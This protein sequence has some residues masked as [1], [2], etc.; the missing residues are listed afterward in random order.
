MYPCAMASEGTSGKW[1]LGTHPKRLGGIAEL[2]ATEASVSARAGDLRQAG[3]KVEIFLSQLGSPGSLSA[4]RLTAEPPAEADRS[5]SAAKE[6]VRPFQVVEPTAVA[7]GLGVAG[8]TL[9]KRGAMSGLFWFIAGFASC[10]AVS[11]FGVALVVWGLP[12]AR[13]Q[14][15]DESLPNSREPSH[16]K[17]LFFPDSSSS[18]WEIRPLKDWHA[19][20]ARG[21]AFE[22]RGDIAAPRRSK[23]IAR[24]GEGRAG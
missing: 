24:P 14:A 19:S 21:F 13:E 10:L 17:P 16:P 2:Y 7:H 5:R 12:P 23:R 18:G 4:R 15:K 1:S 20:K 11:L 6:P 22:N 8:A 3:Y 9:L